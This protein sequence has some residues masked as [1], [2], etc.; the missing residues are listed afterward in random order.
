VNKFLLFFLLTVGGILAYAFWPEKELKHPPG[1]FIKEQPYQKNLPGTQYWQKDEFT[2]RAL[3]EFKI[4]ARVLSTNYF[5]SG[6]EKKISPVDFALG[7]GPMSDQ[8][9]LDYITISQRSRWY[10]WKADFY[11]IPRDQISLNS[12]NMHIVPA[13]ADIEDLLSEVYKGSIVEIEGYLV[14]ITAE[15]GWKWKS[16]LRRDDTGGGACEIVWVDKITIADEIL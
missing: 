1:I 6:T 4:K 13:N 12:A 3:A 2:I 10:K 14:E 15:K 5:W 8:A 9:V 16:S 7:W 11:P